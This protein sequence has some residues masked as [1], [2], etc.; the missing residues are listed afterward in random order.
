MDEKDAKA[1]A[2]Q[3]EGKIFVVMGGSYWCFPESNTSQA[4]S[5][6]QG[7]LPSVK[8]FSSPLVLAKAPRSLN[9]DVSDDDNSDDYEVS[10]VHEI[11]PCMTIC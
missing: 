2:L 9:Y 6:S 8:R 1:R 10:G 11:T 4:R 7:L 5:C 3:R